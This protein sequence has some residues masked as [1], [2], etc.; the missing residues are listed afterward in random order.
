MKPSDFVEQYLG[1]KLY[2]YQKTYL[3][4]AMQDININQYKAET[5]VS[6]VEHYHIGE[7]KDLDYEYFC[8]I[9]RS[10]LGGHENYCWSCGKE[11]EW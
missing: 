3:N 5:S 6:P 11:L 2:R 1:I 10:G 7:C 4:F 8:L 9:C